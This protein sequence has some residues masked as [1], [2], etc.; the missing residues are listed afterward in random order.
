MTKEELLKSLE[1]YNPEAKGNRITIFTTEDRVSLLKSLAKSLNGLY[2]EKASSSAGETSVG[3]FKIQAKKPKGAGGG[4]GAGA[5]ITA[6]GESAQCYYCAAAWYGKDFSDKTLRATAEYVNA[7]VGVEKV[8]SDLPEQWIESCRKSAEALHSR[9]GTK[10][11]VFHRGSALVDAINSNFNSVNKEFGY[12]TNINKWTPADIWMVE[13][14]SGIGPDSFAFKDFDNFN[15]FLLKKAKDKSLF[16][17]SLK[18]TK[19]ASVL[20]INFSKKRHEYQYT[21]ATTGKRG[22]FESKDVYILFSDGEIQFRTFPTWQG[23]IK[24][25]TAN[26]GKVSGGPLKTIISKF[27]SSEKMD[28][29]S[30]VEAWIRSKNKQ[31]YKDFYGYYKSVESKPMSEKEFVA[32]MSTKETNWQS[33]KYLGVQLVYIMK[34]SSKT[35]EILSAIINYAKSQSDY[36]APHIKVM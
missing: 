10:K 16:G 6:L 23:E 36:S 7:D 11:Y 8:I 35:Q 2:S 26:H 1:K 5:E 20:E 13:E 3:P 24:G 17:I 21:G 33:S 9:Y 32:T 30:T 31:F 12:F 19:T 27:E 15:S 25:K 28:A 22:F 18:Q 29:Q 34:N 4:S 14:K